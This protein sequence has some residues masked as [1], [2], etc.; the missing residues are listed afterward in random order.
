MTQTNQIIPTMCRGIRGATTAAENTRDAILEATREMLYI[1]IRANHIVADDVASIY[2]TT[3]M[4][5]N[6]EYPA[7]AARQLGYYDTALLCGH[8]MQIPG[9][10]PRCIRVLM[11][12]NTTRNT[13][14]II[15]VYLRDAKG[16]RP[17]RKTL[18]A[19]PESEIEAVL[20]D[21]DV[22]SLKFDP[23]GIRK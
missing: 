11:H 23:D 18:P 15:H 7:L 2:F 5:L 13:K 22:N 6:A 20:K 1:M 21:L 17:D 4:D 16:L 3:T 19:I 14:E 10:L 8:E 12:W 9:G